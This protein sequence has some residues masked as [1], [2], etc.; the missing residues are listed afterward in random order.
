MIQVISTIFSGS[1][2][3]LLR[4]KNWTSME[5]TGDLSLGTLY[6]SP[7]Q[8]ARV[9]SESWIAR[10][11]FCLACKSDS[12]LRSRNNNR[13]TDFTCADCAHPYELKTFQRRPTRRLLNGA[14]QPLISRIVQGTPPTLLLLQRR[15]PWSI[16]SLSA[17]HSSFLTPDVVEARV[18]LRE[19]AQ[20]AGWVGCSIRLDLLGPDA[21]IQIVQNGKFLSRTGAR[22]H[23]Q[24]FTFL[25]QVPMGQ[26]S[27]T[28]L[29]LKVV[30]DIGKDQFC[31]SDVYE[32]EAIFRE[33][34]PT[35]RYI[36][37][38]LRQQLQVLRDQRLIDFLGDG[39][40]RIIG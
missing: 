16:I 14:Y 13:C 6:R 7:S 19:T 1:V 25:D 28:S 17:I 24:R 27:W 39:R 31:L 20:R 40:Y 26:R 22:R 33:M 10:Y 9:I 12:L 2:T 8:K 35:N 34:Y 18:P 37:P 11:G 4:E 30:R 32:R 15:H 29:L 36:R 23:F 5:L 38:K 21:E 3:D